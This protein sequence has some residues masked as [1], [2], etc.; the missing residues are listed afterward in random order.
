[1]LKFI[2]VGIKSERDD[3]SCCHRCCHDSV[4]LCFFSSSTASERCV[5]YIF[6]LIITAVSVTE[7][8]TCDFCY[9]V[10]AIF[11]YWS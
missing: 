5:Q 6:L 2:V 11:T 9:S 7:S 3:G 1:M 8:V 10:S 4:V